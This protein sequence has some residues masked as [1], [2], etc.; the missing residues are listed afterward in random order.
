MF[1]FTILPDK[2]ESELMESQFDSLQA[3]RVER[4]LP[5]FPQQNQLLVTLFLLEK[6]KKPPEMS[7]T[8]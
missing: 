8:F 1:L 2:P 5:H 4:L 7:A 6:Y 3:L